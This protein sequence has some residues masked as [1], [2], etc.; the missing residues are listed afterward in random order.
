MLSTAPAVEGAPDDQTSWE[1]VPGLRRYFDFVQAAYLRLIVLGGWLLFL[2]Y[3]AILQNTP[4]V[5]WIASSTASVVA[6]V[7][8]AAMLTALLYWVFLP[9]AIDRRIRIRHV[10]IAGGLTIGA[11]VALE[12]IQSLYS[13]AR[14]FQESDMLAGSVGAAFS[15]M[16]LVALTEVGV[17]R[18]FISIGTLMGL[19]VLTGSVVASLFVWNPEY[20]YRGDHW[21]AQ[22]IVVACGELLPPFAAFSGGVHA[23]GE[24]GIHVHP[25]TAEEEGAN[26]TLG[27]FFQR[28]GGSLSENTLVLPSGKT[29]TNGDTCP[30]GEEG[31]LRVSGFKPSTMQ[32]LSRIENPANH[33]PRNY[34]T[35][36]IEFV[37]VGD[38]N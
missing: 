25:R 13:D 21:H 34:Q 32:R 24:R 4:R 16:A 26:A 38:N 37:T 3:L 8:T 7:V 36:L 15:A 6:H 2:A 28:A 22:Y 20:P 19:T 5:P 11:V 30:N 14:N 23:H 35:V 18:G 31:Q 33:V 12:L 9:H 27:L 1:W 17:P 10:F 29:Y